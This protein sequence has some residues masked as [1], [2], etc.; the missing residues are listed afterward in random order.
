MNQETHRL[1]ALSSSLISG[2][3]APMWVGL[4]VVGGCGSPA[5]VPPPRPSVTAPQPVA[6]VSPPPTSAAP[7]AATLPVG[8]APARIDILPL[9]E[10]AETGGDGSGATLKAYV[11]LLDG[12]GS[13]IKAPGILRFE[14]Y[15]HV[16]RSAEAKGQRIAIWPDVDVTAPSENNEYWLDFLRAYEFALETQ[17]DPENVYI[18]EVTCLYSEGTRFTDE[19]TLRPPD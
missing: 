14:L 6:P 2:T 19:F 4:V 18:L 12:F 1:H 7:A 3:I 10:L 11:R 16:S 8:F 17:A 5:P 13:P 15:D 9:T